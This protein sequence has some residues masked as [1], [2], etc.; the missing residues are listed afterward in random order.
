MAISV[1]SGWWVMVCPAAAQAPRLPA[2]TPSP[3][4]PSAPGAPAAPKP[5]PPVEIK[6]K[7]EVV[8]PKEKPAP[9]K[10]AGNRQKK[11]KKKE[12]SSAASF[13]PKSLL[14]K[15]VMNADSDGDGMLSTEEFRK[16]PLLKELKKERVDS[17]FADIDADQNAKLDA[18]E[19][20]QG[21]GKITA[22]AKDSR[23]MIDDGEAAKQAKKIS[24]LTK[25]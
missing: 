9:K 21:F 6:T 19:I 23:S 16:V 17:L 24:R 13:D 10:T 11:S 8:K 18:D 1:V 12:E 25:K 15:L 20:G 5:A 22:L 3:A 14:V 7:A 2:A 4:G